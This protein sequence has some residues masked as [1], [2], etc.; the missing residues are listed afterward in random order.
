MTMHKTTLSLDL[1]RFGGVRALAPLMAKAALPVGEGEKA[2]DDPGGPS[3][4][5]ESILLNSS[6]EERKDKENNIEITIGSTR[7]TRTS[8]TAGIGLEPSV[9]KFSSDFMD[10]GDICT[11]WTP[12]SWANEL[13]RKASCCDQIRPDIA[14][15]YRRWAGDIEKRL[16]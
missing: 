6:H 11:G 5:S 2:I 15:H 12:E 3:G 13:R 8:V 1:S 9:F 7:T 10:F 14:D 16:P 4:P